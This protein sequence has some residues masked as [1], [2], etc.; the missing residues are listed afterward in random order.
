MEYREDIGAACRYLEHE[1]SKLE[2]EYYEGKVVYQ[3]NE[4]EGKRKA[5]AHINKVA[6]I[7]RE[8][9]DRFEKRCLPKEEE[10]EYRKTQ[11]I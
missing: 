11:I 7:V 10:N 3:W 4:L 1:A 6:R 8:H 5:L 2:S 9:L